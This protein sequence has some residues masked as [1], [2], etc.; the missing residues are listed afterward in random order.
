MLPAELPGGPRRP[1]PPTLQLGLGAA[2]LG[3]SG[4]FIAL[5]SVSTA[6]TILV[7][8]LIAAPILA[9]LAWSEYRKHGPLPRRVLVVQLVAGVLLGVDMA[10]WA[11][12]VILV[13]AG[14]SSVLVNIQVVVAPLLALCVTGKRPSKAYVVAV[15]FLLSGV[16]LT[17]GIAQ[18]AADLGTIVFGSAL[19]LVAGIC[20]GAYVFAIGAWCPPNRAS[21]QVF[22]SS[23]V[24]WGTGTVLSLVWDP[25]DLSPGWAAVGWLA[26]LAIVGQVAGWILVGMSLPRLNP[27]V[28]ASILMLQ[29]VLAVVLGVVVLG[30][31]LSL[32]Q[33]VGVG[34]VTIAI[35]VVAM[36]SRR[37][38][39]PIR[40]DDH[41]SDRVRS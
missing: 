39:R 24:A 40:G 32:T 15:P 7:R 14:V 17:S 25:V 19:A 33:V 10:A 29:P 8:Y 38:K 12:S 20:Y 9:A 28:G 23:L 5:A 37:G 30:E 13:G 36:P 3:A 34:M 2:A 22:C 31:R 16:A 26:A 1:L 11:Q 35:R 6:T 27:G 4:I 18:P 21:S 41:T